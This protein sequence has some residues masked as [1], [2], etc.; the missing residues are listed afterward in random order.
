[1]TSMISQRIARI[2]RFAG[3]VVLT[4]LTGLQ[5]QTVGMS[6]ALVLRSQAASIA[7]ESFKKMS[8]SISGV[9]NVGIL[10]TG[11]TAR[12]LVENA[13]LDLL[14]RKGIRVSLQSSPSSLKQSI[15]LNV[16]DQSVRYA[17]LANGEYRREIQTAIEARHTSN[18]TAMAEYL[19]L[20]KRQDVDTV[21][22]RED[23]GM[24]SDV[25]DGER[26]L[27]DKLLGPI[28]MIG[29]AFLIVYLFFT[30]RN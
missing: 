4:F 13:F 14:G 22:F 28:L 25:H 18:D 8:P 1:M 12:A 20:F 21:A 23:A 3:L 17:G 26:T 15:Q 27:F 2:V 30:V 10:V 16:L 7:D 9:D 24:V 5:A 6:A 19:G 29:G 11:G